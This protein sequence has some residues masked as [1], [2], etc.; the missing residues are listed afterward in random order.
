MRRWTRS[1]LGPAALALGVLL[2]A[3]GGAAGDGT[4]AVASAGD[5]KAT[6]ASEKKGDV[7]REQ[8]GLD[9]ARCMREHGVDVPDPTADG[10][11]LTIVGPGP[12]SGTGPETGAGPPP[13]IDEADKACRHFL[14]G[15]IQAGGGPIDPA[16]QDKAL[17]FAQCMRD[18]GVDM[19]DPDFSNGGVQIR[20]GGDGAQPAPETVDAAQKACGGL[21]GPGRGGP[22]ETFGKGT[23]S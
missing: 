9:F 17:R 16:E 23:R 21:F 8:A 19:P 15:L 6:T 22:G 5:G 13:G 11:G 2:T 4:P 10:K 1:V 18:H 3:C 12:G 20:I 14:D 7:D